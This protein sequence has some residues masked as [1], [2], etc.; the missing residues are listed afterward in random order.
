MCHLP[1]NLLGAVKWRLAFCRR[2]TV[3]NYNYQRSERTTYYLDLSEISNHL[4]LKSLFPTPYLTEVHLPCTA[5]SRLHGGGCVLIPIRLTSRINLRSHWFWSYLYLRSLTFLFSFFEVQPDNARL[6]HMLDQ[7]SRYLRN[8][9]YCSSAE[10]RAQGNSI[11]L[12]QV[13]SRTLSRYTH[14][15][16]VRYPILTERWANFQSNRVHLGPILRRQKL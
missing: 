4:R 6:R 15:A 10:I 2:C 8:P 1:L 13:S 11:I 5:P 14:P 12:I 9:W 7:A 16:V 3:S